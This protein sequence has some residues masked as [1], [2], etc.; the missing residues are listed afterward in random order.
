[1]FEHFIHFRRNLV[2]PHNSV[3]PTLMTCQPRSAQVST[4]DDSV[5]KPGHP[6]EMVG[7]TSE[8]V[9]ANRT[10][11]GVGGASYLAADSNS[12]NRHPVICDARSDTQH[13]VTD[14]TVDSTTP[15]LSIKTEVEIKQESELETTFYGT[16]DEATNSI[17]IIYP[18]EENADI[19][20][21]ECVQEVST[22]DGVVCQAMDDTVAAA[23]N[24]RYLTP[25]PHHSYS[26]E[27]SPAYTCRTDTM[28]PASINSDTDSCIVT[29][30]DSASSMDCGYE[31]HD[32]PSVDSHCRNTYFNDLWHE[33]FRELFPA[34]A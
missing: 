11:G 23:T 8:N 9:E 16:Y 1:M 22:D 3:V 12:S 28:S 27:F 15:S 14:A 34:L 32:S 6:K 10:T 33:N 7:Q 19:G 26:T 2:F 25:P 24:V 17:T 20:I 18:G 13:M 5:K 29:Q 30:M 21:Q 4:K 31:S